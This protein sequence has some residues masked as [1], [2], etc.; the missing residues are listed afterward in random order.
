MYKQGN[1]SKIAINIIK[2]S[3][4]N[5]NKCQDE[6]HKNMKSWMK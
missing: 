5:M 6:E 3:K 2:K 4:E 1:T